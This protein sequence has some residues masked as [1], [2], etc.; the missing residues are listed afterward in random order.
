M[1]GIVGAVLPGA[2]GSEAASVA[3]LGLFALQHRGQE[4]AG[5]AVS[6]GE[7]LMVYK[8]LGLIASVLLYAWARL[9]GHARRRITGRDIPLILTLGASACLA[10]RARVYVGPD[11]AMTHIAAAL[12]VPTVALFGP[13][14]TVKWGPWPR[15]HAVESNP[16]RRCGSQHVNNVMLVQG[17]T[18]CAP[19]MLEGCGRSI[20]SFSDCLQHLPASRVMAAIDQALGVGPRG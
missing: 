12:G 13:S 3:A 7:Q 4:S 2:I 17:A 18:A 15:G 20:G 14:N 16:W 8:D 10:S 11:T 6:D 1:C 19:C 5:L 9:Q